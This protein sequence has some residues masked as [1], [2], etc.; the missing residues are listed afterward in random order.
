MHQARLL[1][2]CGDKPSPCLEGR[3][4]NHPVVDLILAVIA[5][6]LAAFAYWHDHQETRR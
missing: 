6:S 5:V 2:Q 4:N 3:N 1:P